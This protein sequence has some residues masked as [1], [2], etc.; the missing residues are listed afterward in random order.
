M[1]LRT[2][3]IFIRSFRALVKCVGMFTY[4]NRVCPVSLS[5]GMPG[6]RGHRR[7]GHIALFIILSLD[8]LVKNDAVFAGAGVVF[9]SGKAVGVRLADHFHPE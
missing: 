7:T 5:A 4:A 9:Y 6:E 1:V 8:R 2:I 3:S